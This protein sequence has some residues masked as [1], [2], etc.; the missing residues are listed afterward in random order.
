MA[1]GVGWNLLGQAAPIATALACIPVLTRALGTD[2]FGLLALSWTFVGYFSI[3]DLGLGQAMTR[4]VA[5]KLAVGDEESV[6]AT[7]WTTLT[8]VLAFGLVGLTVAWLAAPTIAHALRTSHALQAEAL[9][10]VHLLALSIPVVMTSVGLRGVLGAHLRFKLVSALGIPLGMW[11]YIGPIAALPISH[12]L[13]LIVGVL[14]LGRVAGFLLYLG[15]SL[16]VVPGLRLI[17]LRWSLVRPLLSFGGWLTLDSTID[18][19]V[20]FLDRFLLGALLSVAAVAFYA[21]PYQ[22]AAQA[23]ILATA[24]SGVLFPTFTRV[25]ALDIAQA[26][27]FF[28]R[29]VK[30]LLFAMFPL[31]LLM[32]GLARPGLHLW[33]GGSYASKSATVLQLVAIGVLVTSIGSV[34][35]TFNASAGRPD[36]NAKLGLLKLVLHVAPLWWVVPNYGVVGLAALWMACAGVEALG[37]MLYATARLAIARRQTVRRAIQS[38][39]LWAVLALAALDLPL[40]VKL[41]YLAVVISGTGL[42]A[43]NRLL[44]RAEKQ[45]LWSRLGLRAA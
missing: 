16:R 34:A 40:Q 12:S 25:I 2:R 38:L 31:A 5:H 29:A 20:N 26:R 32:V 18:P 24:V 27:L 1:R 41:V 3:F 10:T 8:V 44:S 28:R 30:Y 35:G 22:L 37:M 4:S 15:F 17:A 43:W 9:Q 39:V 13:T 7:V 11:S 23:W 6:P 19:L 21:V 36:V 45:L 33:L 42:F 14:L